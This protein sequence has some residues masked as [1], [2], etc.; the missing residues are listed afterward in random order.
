MELALRKPLTFLNP[1]IRD[2]KSNEGARRDHD[3]RH[4]SEV[5][6]VGQKVAETAIPG[7]GGEVPLG[8]EA[9]PKRHEPAEQ[10]DSSR[11]PPK[12]TGTQPK[13]PARQDH[14]V[15]ALP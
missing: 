6:E 4:W 9:Q 11:F 3:Q 12:K 8:E 5:V 1:A 2:P 10:R 13:Q 15:E 14:P 7:E